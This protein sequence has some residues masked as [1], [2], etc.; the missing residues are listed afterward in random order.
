MNDSSSIKDFTPSAQ[1][2]RFFSTMSIVLVL[3]ILTG[4][5]NTYLPKIWG[6]HSADV[7]GIIHF[8]AVVFALWLAFFVFQVTLIF[9]KKIALH[10]KLGNWG[11]AFSVVMLLTGFA[12]GIASAKAGHL[13]IPGVMFPDPEGFL[14]LNINSIIVFTSL[15]LLGWV[16]RHNA[17]AHKRLM[18]MA[19]AGGLT[20]PGA[21]RLPL[22][23]GT[24]AIAP[25]ALALI[26]AAPVYDLI[27][28]RKLH[29]AYIP[30]IA[31]PLL[32]IPPVVELIASTEAWKQIA[33]WLMQL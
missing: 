5:S 15:S 20:P 1:E 16:Y 4:F 9:R 3:V 17:S 22:V 26:I 8:H 7:P 18:L 31:L 12:A 10:R 24:A 2:H 13:G 32:S 6:G 23:A 30:G 11:I 33:H 19:T 27:K 21:A 25:V 14:L 28:Y 29:W